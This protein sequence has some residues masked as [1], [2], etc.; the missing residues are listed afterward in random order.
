MVALGDSEPIGADMLACVQCHGPRGRGGWEAGADVP[1]IRWSRLASPHGILDRFGH[2]RPA[3]TQELFRRAV[4]SGSD[5]S[6]APLDIVM[7]RFHIA[8]EDLADLLAY[9][10]I[11]GQEPVPG[12]GDSAIRVGVLLPVDGN[13]GDQGQAVWRVVAR[14][15]EEVNREGGIHGRVVEP[16]VRACGPDASSALAAARVLVEG[17]DAVLCFLACS[18]PG[19]GEEVRAYLREREVPQVGSITMPMQSP[20]QDDETFLLLPSLA[21]QAEA[22]AIHLFKTDPRARVA[23]VKG[24]LAAGS[25]TVF[26]AFLEKAQGLGLAVVPRDLQELGPVGMASLQKEG[27]DRVALAGGPD[28][29]ILFLSRARAVGFRS[30]LLVWGALGGSFDTRGHGTI[31]VLPP[32]GPG[33]SADGE[34]RVRTLVESLR[35]EG[36]L[37]SAH[38]GVQLVAFA[39]ADLLVHVLK[40]AGRDLDRE[41]LRRELADVRDF[42]TGVLPPLTFGRYDREGVRGAICVTLDPSGD[43]VGRTWV[44]ADR[45]RIPGPARRDS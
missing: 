15:M 17:R 11:I 31:L 45:D 41:G 13:D 39:A 14:A 37:D 12:V 28:D 34:G 22:A 35:R 6:G 5:S 1:D 4:T 38:V 8:D 40:R 16:V 43:R 32:V 29:L 20:A 30:P 36:Q 24:E 10:Q 25:G 27:I 19:A 3:Y 7:P 9:L 21:T 44:P 18:G 26:T 42:A 2:L 33:L 23:V